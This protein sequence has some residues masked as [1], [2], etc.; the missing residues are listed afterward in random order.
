MVLKTYKEVKPHSS[1]ESEDKVVEGERDKYEMMS[2]YI[3]SS[4][5]EHLQEA[6]DGMGDGVG[7]RTAHM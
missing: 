7:W 2:R 3:I 1:E 4:W 6:E 5:G